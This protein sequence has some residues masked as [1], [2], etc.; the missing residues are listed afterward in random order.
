MTTMPHLG[1]DMIHSSAVATPVFLST[2]CAEDTPCVRT[3]LMSELVMRLSL[4]SGVEE[5]QTSGDRWMQASATTTSTAAMG[6]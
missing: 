5:I 3:D 4:V 6:I 2:R 1:L